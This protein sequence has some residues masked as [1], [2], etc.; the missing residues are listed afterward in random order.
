MCFQFIKY[1]EN[2]PNI[3]T[4]HF[5]DFGDKFENIQKLLE[6]VILENYGCIASFLQ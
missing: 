5:E 2:I 4:K 6:V 3:N 1:K